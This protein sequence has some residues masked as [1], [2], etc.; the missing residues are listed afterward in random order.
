MPSP[1]PPPSA[2]LPPSH[3]T[4][5]HLLSS[6]TNKFCSLPEIRDVRD[7]RLRRLGD[8]ITQ[9]VVGPMPVQ[10]FL[11]RFLPQPSD[12]SYDIRLNGFKQGMFSSVPFNS[13]SEKTWYDPFVSSDPRRPPQ[14]FFG[15]MTLIVP[16]QIEVISGHVSNLVIINTSNK[17]DSVKPD[18]S[19]Y[20]KE[21]KTN[22]FDITRV[23][24]FIE[25]KRE[26]LF[27]VNT[28]R[29]T[30]RHNS[31][32]F[33]LSQGN[34]GQITAYA[35]SI[36]SA[37]Y[38]THLFSVLV[39]KDSARLIRWDRGGA[40]VTDPIA[41]NTEPHLLDFFIRYDIAGREARGHDTNVGPATQD[42]IKLAKDTV[43]ELR[44][45]QSFL[46]VTIPGDQS[47]NRYVIPSP[48]VRQESPVGRW[49]RASIALDVSHRCRVLVK[50]SW[51]VV[52][53]DIKPE[54]EVY[55]RLHDHQVS[56]IPSLLSAGDV[57]TN[58][59]HQSQTKAVIRLIPDVGAAGADIERRFDV[60]R[61]YRIVLGT[62]GT[63]LEDFKST[64]EF[65]N[66]MRAALRGVTILNSLST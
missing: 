34:L 22:K 4:P 59:F 56:N 23:D 32:D 17:G 28:P 49:T 53:D 51:R 24:L 21:N 2:A 33:V 43:D 39:L 62:I 10:V 40:V 44:D 46:A 37:Q 61:H 9:F 29:N 27:S 1:T 50:D 54:G 30:S 16:L 47:S 19:A 8:E 7:V 14:L 20:T 15:L 42:E 26:D 66:A 25:M 45:V 12:S 58:T 11:D 38:R 64:R 63:K 57:G 18:C 5:I 41:F 52:H 55:R 60:Y 31:S 48:Q 3:G 6:T 36:L 13:Q 65:V 35:T